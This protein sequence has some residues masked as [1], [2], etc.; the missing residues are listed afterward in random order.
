VTITASSSSNSYWHKT[1][2]ES[3]PLHDYGGNWANAEQRMIR[4]T[5]GQ[6]LPGG[7]RYTEA[8]LPVA[9]TWC[10]VFFMGK[11]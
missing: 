2:R 4:D 9:S 3:D 6:G 5:Q 1:K 8:Q 10:P 7:A 11:S